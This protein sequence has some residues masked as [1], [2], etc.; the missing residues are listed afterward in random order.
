MRALLDVNVLIALL[1]AGHAMHLRA[2]EW[3]AKQSD[4]GW[5]SC[6][7]TQNGVVRIMS[8]PSYPT[9]RPAALVAQRLASACL[10]PEHNFWSADVSLLAAG[11]IDWQRLLGHRQVT[12]AYL[13][14]LA[15]RQQ[16]KLAT[17]DQRIRPDLVLGAKPV[18]LEIIG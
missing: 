1:D 8:Q 11:L 12:D 5:A 4:Y 18:H 7:L 16:G 17:F 10:A 14:A 3:L 15:V 9:P 6:P 2:T 13:L